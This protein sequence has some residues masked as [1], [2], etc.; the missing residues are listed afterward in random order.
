MATSMDISHI[1][2][3]H[4]PNIDQPLTDYIIAVLTSES[5]NSPDEVQEAIGEVLYSCI[6]DILSNNNKS[7]TNEIETICLKLYNVLHCNEE[8]DR[9]EQKL[10]EPIH[11]GTMASDFD[12]LEK[13]S[14]QSI[15]NLSKKVESKVDTKKLQKAEEKLKQKAEKRD[16]IAPIEAALPMSHIEATVSQVLSKKTTKQET[17]GINKTKDIKVE[18]FDLSFGSHVL[19]QGAELSLSNFYSFQMFY[20]V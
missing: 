9:D 12:T 1:I 19:L 13:D 20:F 18:N 15:W 8:D 17:S 2:L 6:N 16:L 14:N 4:I 10:L 11:L 7:S 5:Y 3:D